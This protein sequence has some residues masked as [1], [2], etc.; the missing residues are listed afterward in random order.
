MLSITSFRF[1]SILNKIGFLAN[2]IYIS[3]RKLSELAS[4]V[5]SAKF[6][7]GNI[8]HLKTCKTY[9]TS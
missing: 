9:K 5:I 2:E 6:V 8:T 3:T 4:K 7:I 1:T